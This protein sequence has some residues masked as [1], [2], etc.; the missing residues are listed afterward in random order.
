M[1]F[2]APPFREPCPASRARGQGERGRTAHLRVRRNVLNPRLR[3]RTLK[4]CKGPGLERG[5]GGGP[6]RRLDR[7]RDPLRVPRVEVTRP[8][9]WSACG[10]PPP[11]SE[12]L[13]IEAA[14]DAFG[15]PPALR[16][17]GPKEGPER[18]PP[19][20]HKAHQTVVPAGPPHHKARKT[21]LESPKT[22]ETNGAAVPGRGA[23][24]Q[25][26][27]PSKDLTKLAPLKTH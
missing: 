15:G 11:S 20:G 27:P 2:L 12:I 22:R 25:R 23:F 19:L 9:L 1:L 18:R 10:G 8:T 6:S 13:G 21:P 24:C 7:E 5:P 16:C 17:A 26:P 3:G 14:H 4:V